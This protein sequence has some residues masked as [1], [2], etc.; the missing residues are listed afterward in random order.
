MVER[1]DLTIFGSIL[2]NQSLQPNTLSD[3][4][5]CGWSLESTECRLGSGLWYRPPGK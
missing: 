3:L 2:L 5:L 1:V 4:S